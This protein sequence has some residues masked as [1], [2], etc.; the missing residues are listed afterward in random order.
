M[1]RHLGPLTGVTGGWAEEWKGTQEWVLAPRAAECGLRKRAQRA[2]RRSSL[3]DHRTFARRS[4]AREGRWYYVEGERQLISAAGSPPTLLPCQQSPLLTGGAQVL[5]ASLQERGARP[6]RPLAESETRRLN[7]A[8][9]ARCCRVSEVRGPF[10]SP[11]PMESVDRWPLA[12]L[13]LQIPG[14]A[15]PRE[16]PFVGVS[17]GLDPPPRAVCRSLPAPARAIPGRVY[18]RADRFLGATVG[19]L[20]G[21]LCT[22]GAPG[23]RCGRALRC[24]FQSEAYVTRCLF[25]GFGN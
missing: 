20:D 24:P 25:G 2:S 7:H 23:C 6:P 3:L 4:V 10:S 11:A 9:G 5:R 1:H 14:G 13:L 19:Q 12:S 16:P 8:R 22:P 18:L 21:H 17:A 15:A